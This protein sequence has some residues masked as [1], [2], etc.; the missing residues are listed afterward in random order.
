M[1]VDTSVILVELGG[2]L[3]VLAVLARLAHRLTIPAIPLFLLAG[4]AVGEGGLLP[5]V[6][7]RSFAQPAAII[8]LVLLLFVMGLEHT[9]EELVGTLRGGAVV[10]VVNAVACF[11]PGFVAGLLLGW[12][13]LPA[14]LLGGV[15]Y[16]ASG[17]IISKV[18]HDLGRMR[19]PEMPVILSLLVPQDLAMAVYLPVVG[20]LLVGAGAA[21]TA[22]AVGIALGVAAL[23]LLMALRYGHVLSRLVW[24]PSDEVLLLTILGVVLLVA[25]VADEVQVSAAIGAYL[26]GVALQGRAA[27]RARVLLLPLRDLFAAVFFLEFGLLID[28]VDLPPVLL[29]GVALALATALLQAGVGWWSARRAQL[30]RR[31]RVRTAV[32]MIARGE[33]SIVI[34]GIAATSG[35]EAD[36]PPLAGVFVLLLAIA[37]PVLMRFSDTLA[38]GAAAGSRRESETS[39]D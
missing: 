33:F 4:L 31:S 9:S 26:A 15:T 11:T 34:A 6:T 21:A 3:V 30:G 1:S 20:A 22:G 25:G 5:L 16:N 35:V 7:V 2:I 29:A 27:E 17:G 23:A 12:D 24:S 28:P 18:L 19:T 13:L 39:D 38:P 32:T 37:G 36:L 10:G 8:G 14:A